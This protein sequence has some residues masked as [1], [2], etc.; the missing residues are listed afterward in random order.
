MTP[1]E[2]ARAKLAKDVPGIIEEPEVYG[3]VSH[4]YG[5]GGVSRDVSKDVCTISELYKPM[6]GKPSIRSNRCVICGQPATNQHH[7]VKRSAGKWVRDGIELKKPTMS[8]CGMG[9]ASGCHGLA[10]AGRL[11][12]RWAVTRTVPKSSKEE[13]LAAALV[14]GHWEA[15][16]TNQ[17]CTYQQALANEEGWHRISGKDVEPKVRGAAKIRM[18]PVLVDGKLYESQR[19]AAIALGCTPGVI[20]YRADN[21]IDY[22]GHTIEWTDKE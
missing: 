14:G 8:L 10:H 12:F 15:K 2:L 18:T 13:G 11:H 9:N 17:P 3:R 19:A 16:L 6:M 21:G 22:E 5:T 7:V 4:T 1:W 20:K